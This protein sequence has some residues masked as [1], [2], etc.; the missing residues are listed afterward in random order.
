[1]TRLVGAGDRKLDNS[2]P[3]SNEDMRL[4]Y[5]ITMKIVQMET[6]AAQFAQ[7]LKVIKLFGPISNPMFDFQP[8]LRKAPRIFECGG[9]ACIHKS[10]GPHEL[11]DGLIKSIIKMGFISSK[12]VQFT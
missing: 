4:Q 6:L 7:Y 5:R 11:Q 3:E 10:A 1:M 2:T 12:L 8:K 9:A